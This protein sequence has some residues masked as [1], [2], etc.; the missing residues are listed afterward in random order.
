MRQ[1]LGS[2][3]QVV[4]LGPETDYGLFAASEPGSKSGVWLDLDLQIE[5]YMGEGKP[6]VLKSEVNHVMS[7]KNCLSS[8]YL[9]DT[10]AYLKRMRLL[11][12]KTPDN[13]NRTMM[14]EEAKTVDQLM[15]VICQRIGITNTQEY[16]LASP[17][18]AEVENVD[19]MRETK[20]RELDALRSKI[21]TEAEGQFGH[22]EFLS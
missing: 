21:H 4:K 19:T 13:A 7:P 10:L 18:K 2:Q 20:A 3:A 14:V 15:D 8:Q 5:D 22:L 12:V 11:K 16:S 6:V 1:K 9:Q 17:R